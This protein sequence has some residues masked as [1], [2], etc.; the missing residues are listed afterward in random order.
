MFYL[1]RRCRVS[2]IQERRHCFVSWWYEWTSVFT[3]SR[4]HVKCHEMAGSKRQTSRFPILHCVFFQAVISELKYLITHRFWTWWPS[5]RSGWRWSW[6]L[7]WRFAIDWSV[8]KKLIILYT[9]IFPL[10]YKKEGVILDDVWAYVW[11]LKDSNS[12]IGPTWYYGFPPT[13]RLSTDGCV[14][15]ILHELSY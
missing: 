4:K 1:K 6:W 11:N 15:L 8:W 7:W 3:Y 13:G 10:D 9:V 5:Q 2:W 12:C 14:L